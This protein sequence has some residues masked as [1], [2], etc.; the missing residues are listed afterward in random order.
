VTAAA[1]VLA[2]GASTRFGAD[3]LAAMDRGRPVLHHALEAVA[4]VADPVVL[5][6]GPA[7][8]VPRLPSGMG[9]SVRIAR[10]REPHQGPLAG[11]AAGLAA[12]PPGVDRVIVVA[13]DMPSLVPGVLAALLDVLG[14]DGRTVAVR[15]ES[16]PVSPLPLAVDPAVA[17]I[18]ERQLARGR[19]S[20]R[21]LLDEVSAAVLPAASWQV[22][23]P[24]GITL[25]DIDTPEDLASG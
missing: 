11:L 14:A 4:Q 17:G 2:G 22:L 7:A 20:L 3:K 9:S 19:R 16:D 10:D 6:L 13:G 24:Q 5:V 25:R 1:I 15:L 18:A 8:E 12:L 23:D 21:G